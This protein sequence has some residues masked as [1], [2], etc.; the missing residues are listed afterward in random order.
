GTFSVNYTTHPGTALADRDFANTSGTLF[1]GANQTTATLTVDVLGDTL[2]EDDETFTVELTG[3]TN[4]VTLGTHATATGTIL[5][6][7]GPPSV[8]IADVTTPKESGTASF[9][10]TLSAPSG[11]AVTVS[12]RTTGAGTA[13]GLGTAADYRPTVTNITFNPGET[14]K[15]FDVP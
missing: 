14:A 1:F 5:D 4:G 15:T 13:T 11:V 2:D 8:S 3:P 7:D 9:P 12:A 6:D 10:V